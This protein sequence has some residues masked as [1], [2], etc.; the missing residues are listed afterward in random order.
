MH[1]YIN[2]LKSKV[3]ATESI[4]RL[5]NDIAPTRWEV[6][7]IKKAWDDIQEKQEVEISEYRMRIRYLE[8]KLD[9]A[10]VAYVVEENFTKPKK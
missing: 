1:Y 7:E 9:K 10:D 6:D 5:I 3:E 2:H 8:D 4:E